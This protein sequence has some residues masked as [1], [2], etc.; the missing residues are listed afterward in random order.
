ML[1]QV[2][3]HGVYVHVNQLQWKI[4][5]LNMLEKQ[6]DKVLV[7]YVKNNMK[8]KELIRIICFELIQIQ[9]LMQLNVE[10]LQDLLIIVVMYENL[11]FH[12]FLYFIDIII[13]F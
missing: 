6:F 7:I 9:L 1:N 12:S 5:L 3:M 2:Y 10:I 13:T 11:F 4:W 8:S